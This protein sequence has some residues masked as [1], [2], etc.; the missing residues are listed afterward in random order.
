MEQI[1]ASQGLKHIA[2][3]ICKHLDSESYYRLILTNKLTINYSASTF[4]KWLNKCQEK[5][6][7]RDSDWIS[8]IEIAQDHNLEWSMA[9]LFSQIYN[10]NWR[11]KSQY[12]NPLKLASKFGHSKLVR[13][14]LEVGNMKCVPDLNFHNLVDWQKILFVVIKNEKL[15]TF[16]AYEKVL[17]FLSCGS[18]LR[19]PYEFAK[20]QNCKE[21]T[22]LL[23][24]L[25]NRPHSTSGSVPTLII[26]STISFSG[27]RFRV[28]SK[29][30]IKKLQFR[31]L[32]NC[33]KRRQF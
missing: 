31:F 14:I 25:D 27:Q 6:F 24:L 22:K 21:I 30:I 19:M 29:M 1:F 10:K 4:E 28:L 13:L 7:C 18:N 3:K 23:Y 12:N 20:K 15:E 2:D 8:T 26:H 17:T 33:T 32:S 9:I 16:K 11:I 5:G